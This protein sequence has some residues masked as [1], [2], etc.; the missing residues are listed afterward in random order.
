MIPIHIFLNGYP[1]NLT[2]QMSKISGEPE[3]QQ[4]YDE[5]RKLLYS[6]YVM[7]MQDRAEG[8]PKDQFWERFEGILKRHEE[9]MEALS[10]RAVDV[11]NSLTLSRKSESVRHMR[12]MEKIESQIELLQR[13]IDEFGEDRHEEQLRA[14]RNKEAELN[15]QIKNVDLQIKEVNENIIVLKRSNKAL[16]KKKKEAETNLKN[17]HEAMKKKKKE[18]ERKNQSV[19]KQHEQSKKQLAEME[20]EIVELEKREKLCSEL[21]LSLREPIPSIEYIFKDLSNFEYNQN[22]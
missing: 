15:E 3:A 13:Q 2:Y 17:M 20:R 16:N 12:K 1:K 11:R 19:M 8:E 14:L 9:Q 18:I 21:Y 10:Q 4:R 5:S 22:G 7:M 6:L